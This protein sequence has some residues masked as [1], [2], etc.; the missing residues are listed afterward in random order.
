M[1]TSLVIAIVLPLFGSLQSWSQAVSPAGDFKQAISNVPGQQFPRVDSELRCQFQLKAPDAHKVRLHLDK[2]YDMESGTNGVWTITTTP[3]AV[4]FHYYWF[5]VDGANVSDPASETFFGWGHQCSGIEVPSKDEDFYFAKD[6]PHGDVRIKWYYSKISNAW[7]RCFVYTPPDYDKNPAG[8]Y[9]VLYLQHGAGED[10]RGWVNQGRVNF[11]LDNLIATG[12]AKPMIIV[13]DNGSNI[14][15][16]GG[17]DRGAGAAPGQAG[18]TNRP[19][20]GMVGFAG[21]FGKIVTEELIPMIDSSYRTLADQPH[22]GMAGLSMGSM[23]TVQI[24]LANLDKF[25]HIGA[26]SGG[27]VGGNDPQDREQC[28]MADSSAF[29]GKV[30]TL[31]ISVGSKEEPERVRK[32]MRLWMLPGIRN[33]FYESP[34]TAHEWQTWRRSLHEFAPLLFQ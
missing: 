17:R 29:N 21:S 19:P 12:K 25:S 8:R 31:F 6:V 24:T 15:G 33:V 20:G 5:I 28:V 4:G 16:F 13:M 32:T 14:G 10:E 3:Q 22:R 26:F 34:G 9:P 23:Q 7:R 18:S 30:K 27:G 2:D 1:K 11:I